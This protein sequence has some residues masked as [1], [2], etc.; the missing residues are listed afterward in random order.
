MLALVCPARQ[1]DTLRR[2]H[3]ARGVAVIESDMEISWTNLPL[4]FNASVPTMAIEKEIV[5]E[6]QAP[7]LDAPVSTVIVFG[8]RCAGHDTVT[9]AMD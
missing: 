3:L 9:L 8:Q 1:P 4:L 5:L 2:I 7:S 6:D